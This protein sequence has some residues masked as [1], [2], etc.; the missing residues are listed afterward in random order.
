V[1][2][3]KTTA[4]MM[5]AIGESTQIAIVAR[6]PEAKAMTPMMMVD[7]VMGSVLISKTN[8]ISRRQTARREIAK[9]LKWECWEIA[10]ARERNPGTVLMAE[11]YGNGTS[12]VFG[13]GK[14]LVVRK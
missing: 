13:E 5:P 3:T 12:M 7:C 11:D 4:Q 2:I 14:N 6:E 1:I 8:F 9:G 10:R